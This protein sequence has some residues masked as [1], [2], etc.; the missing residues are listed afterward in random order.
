[1]IVGEPSTQRKTAIINANAN[2]AVPDLQ[3]CRRGGRRRVLTGVC[4]VMSIAF[5]DAAQASTANGSLGNGAIVLPTCLIT[6]NTLNFGVYSGTQL[7]ANTTVLVTCTNTTPYNVGLSAGMGSGATVNSRLMTGPA[8]TTLAYSL[9][10]DA[11]R[12]INWGNTPGIDTVSGV[13]IGRSQ[14][15]AVYGRI[16]AAALG[17][18]GIYNYTVIATV[19]Y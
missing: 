10:Q 19:Y 1:M 12:T 8:S 9:Y 17:M 3:T 6:T 14:T 18:P 16:G 15:I 7:D 13:G 5:I 4:A 2:K 11:G